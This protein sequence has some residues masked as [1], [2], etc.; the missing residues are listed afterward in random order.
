MSN[1][2]NVYLGA[3][4]NDETGDP[5][6]NAFD[7]INRNFA[8]VTIALVDIDIAAPVTSVAGRTGNVVLTISDVSG[9]ASTSYV[10]S[11]V[12]ASNIGSQQYTDSQ[13]AAA[14]A[15]VNAELD[16]LFSNAAIQADQ[17]AVLDANLG[18]ATANITVLFN[19]IGAG[20]VTQSD[21]DIINANVS[22]ANAAIITANVYNTA[23]TS[24][25]NAQL[26][27]YIAA[28]TNAANAATITANTVMK[29]YVD[30]QVATTNGNIF[31]ANA[32]MTNYSDYQDGLI[33]AAWTANAASQE[34]QITSLR[35]NIIAA[36]AAIITANTAMKGYVDTQ[37]AT[38]NVLMKG[39]ADNQIAITT[40]NWTANAASQE[41]KITSINANVAG[42]N[43]AI[44]TANTAMK[45][46][47][48]AQ[49]VIV[50]SNIVTAN[51]ATTNHI[52]T[53]NSELSGYINSNT[54]A[55]NGSITTANTAMKGYVD[56]LNLNLSAA[57]LSNTNAANAAAVTANT[58]MTGYV[59]TLRLNALAIQ[60]NTNANIVLANVYNIAYTDTINSELSG[61]IVANTN[62][63]NA[64]IITANTAMKSYVDYNN[65][66][67]TTAWLANAA[68]QEDEIT[69]LRGNIITVNANLNAFET[70]ANATF[71]TS[72]YGNANV[73]TYLPI[74]PTIIGIQSNVST[75]TIDI[76]T[77]ISNAAV[78][79][80]DINS[81]R[82]NINGANA[83]IIT[84]N[85]A[86]K[87]YVDAQT[88]ILN[89]NI[90]ANTNAANAAIITANT[91]MKGYVDTQV[92]TANLAMQGYVDAVT[93]AWTANAAIQSIQLNSLAT[94]ANANTAA[95][96][97]SYAGS[98]GA[99]LTTAAQL[100]ITSIGTLSGLAV[101]GATSLSTLSTTGNVAIGGNLQVTGNINF[102]GDV[103]QNNVT[104]VYGQFFGDPATG[105]DALYAGIPVGY[106]VLPSTP[107]QITTDSNTYAQLN[108]Q[109]LSSGINA[110]SDYV[111]TA[112]NGTDATHYGD[113]GIGSST[114]AY[115]DLTAIG[116]NDIYLLGVGFNSNGPYVG[117]VG[118]VIISSSNGQIKLATGGAHQSNVVAVV[119]NNTFDILSAVISTST[120]SGALQVAGGAGIVGNLYVGGRLVID[121]TGVDVLANLTTT[122]N[123]IIS[124]N[125]NVAGANAAIIT[126]NTAM[127][128]Y[129]DYNDGLTTTAWTANAAS[130]EGK[131]TSINANIVAANA[132]II[133]ANTA[134]Q[135]Y[136]DYQDSLITTAWTANAASQESQITSLRANIIAAN[137]AIITANTAMKSYVDYNDGLTT[138]AWTANAATQSI[139]L[140]SL[141]IGANANTA[142]Y[143]ITA[144]GNIK[145]SSFI[146][147]AGI[148][149]ANGAAYTSPNTSTGDGNVTIVGSAINLTLS[150]PGT[151]TIGSSTAI[152]VITTDVYGR[153]ATLATSVVVAPAGTL[154][155]TA[156]PAA[157]ITSSLTS[158]GTLTSGTWNAGIIGGTYGGTGINNGANTLTLGGSYTL[159]QSVAS[160]SSPTFTGT[161]FSSIPNSA[162]VNSSITLGLTVI[163]LG[164]TVNTI[165]LTG[166]ISGGN[167][168]GSL[169]DNGI[170]VVSTSTG[171]GNLTI[172][173]GGIN[174]TATG[175]GATTAG[176]STAIPIITTDVYG[177]VSTLTTAAVVAPAGT[178]SGSTLAAGVTASSLTSVGTLGSL[179]VTGAITGTSFNSIT[180]LSSTTPA[181]DGVAA[182][183]TSTTVARADH[184]HVAPTSVTGSAGNAPAGTLTGG[185]LN[186]T[187]LASSLTSVGTLASLTVTATIT[188][189]V[190]GS[191]GS[192]AASGIT[193]TT[194]ASGVTASSLT[195]VGTLTSVTVSGVANIS[196]NT[197]V[198]SNIVATANTN[199]QNIGTASNVFA[200]VYATT[201]SGV[202]TTA[203]YADL[204]EN[205]QADRAYAPGTVLMFGGAK[206]VTLASVDTT[207]IAGV[208]S[209]NPAH[210]MNSRL[211]GD[212][213]VA[214]A[215]QG[216]APCRVIGPVEKGDML[217]SAGSGY[218]KVNNTP[219]AGQ[220]IGKAVGEYTENTYAYNIVEIVVGRL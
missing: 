27:G 167:V 117:N 102:T 201:F 199:T 41:G 59:N 173:S 63:A 212:T 106:T 131:I 66:L 194:L 217:V 73:A 72:S 115:D 58:E 147:T 139:A 35:A 69:I 136:V 86:M 200:T 122:T 52:N 210:L 129:V 82:G 75:N 80:N 31:T 24:T 189:S 18:V 187:V 46:Y 166:N 123:S 83:A 77:L 37:V 67:T 128:G 62:A 36:N 39:Y 134:M 95:Y 53:I 15:N 155:G 51:A 50:N 16:T 206:E 154:S 219:L 105:F 171:A 38:A 94:G 133:T 93:T 103:I 193:G 78:Q 218:A 107:F 29:S 99:T 202:S 21:L 17:I 157:V 165:T 104:T 11:Q 142:A 55:V 120:T 8:N 57:I 43:A 150:G 140:N 177:R 181:A 61:Y 47:V 5:L 137:A 87:G 70:Y 179:S 109:N 220:V 26:S 112:D 25:I 48:D 60:G 183:G 90:T 196:G 127:K 146:T 116:T 158:V 14:N 138:T 13:I 40:A 209:T 215:L 205:Y 113:F 143:L 22:A 144:T 119:N 152:P 124:T 12:L 30:A 160:A 89:N 71:G 23:Y 6:R 149:W 79:S 198:G 68:I 207:R 162:L 159:N 125:A 216:R 7:K 213:V 180:G 203:K 175:P 182:V 184:V 186:A 170:R 74:D 114:Y 111:V 81:L 188:G 91:A 32:V 161:N 135:G 1:F 214:V 178:L 176:S 121:G 96:L 64:A 195:S 204:A 197:N 108:Q 169:Y 185:T 118:N 2:A 132:A 172:A 101:S 92:A 148:Y 33:V 163:T 191:A 4:P 100:N 44:I 85:T 20:A 156:L 98:T 84:A 56:T 153:I 97:P 190:S 145:A 164:S 10:N 151:T 208:V 65:G 54:N 19:T 9:S 130:Q 141:A 76:A 34:S 211:Q 28:N 110:S 3:A 42:A 174:L 126:A 168:A 49:T 88:V 45:S 192:V